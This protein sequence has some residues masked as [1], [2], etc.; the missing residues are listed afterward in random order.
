[1]PFLYLCLVLCNDSLVPPGGHCVLPC[2]FLCLVL[3]SV[4]SVTFSIVLF[5]RCNIMRKRKATTVVTGANKNHVDSTNKFTGCAQNLPQTETVT[6][7]SCS[8]RSSSKSSFPDFDC[9][10]WDLGSGLRGG[11]TSAPSP[12]FHQQEPSS[13]V[14]SKM[15]QLQ[16]LRRTGLI[17]TSYREPHQYVTVYHHCPTKTCYL[18]NINFSEMK[19]ERFCL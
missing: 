9:C 13:T 5:F 18:H 3:C 2:L 11:S 14:G 6:S 19:D 15:V 8:E 1:M 16:N 4:C 7:R 10:R 12:P 17:S